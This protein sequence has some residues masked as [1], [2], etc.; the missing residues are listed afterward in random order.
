[1]PERLE[2]GE[3]RGQLEQQRPEL[4]GGESQQQHPRQPQQQ[5]GLPRC[6]HRAPSGGLIYG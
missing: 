4:S 5:P 6:E 1:M 2:P 3:T